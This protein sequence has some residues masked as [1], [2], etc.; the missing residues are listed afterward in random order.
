MPFNECTP[1]SVLAEFMASKAASGIEI[2][3]HLILDGTSNEILSF[4]RRSQKEAGLVLDGAP[5]TLQKVAH[6]RIGSYWKQVVDELKDRKEYFATEDGLVL[7]RS[8]PESMMHQFM[9]PSHILGEDVVGPLD[10]I[11][12]DMAM[13]GVVD[14]AEYKSIVKRYFDGID[15]SDFTDGQ[16]IY[17]N[18]Y[19]D[20]LSDTSRF[21]N[22]T[23]GDWLG[24]K[25]DAMVKGTVQLSPTVIGGN[26]IE[27]FMKGIP[28][29]GKNFLRGMQDLAKLNNGNLMENLFAE[30]P[31]I[32]QQGLYGIEAPNEV[33]KGLL[34]NVTGLMDRPAK[35]LMYFVGLA[36]GGNAAAG[37]KAIQQVMFLPRMADVPLSYRQPVARSATRLLNYTIGTYNLFGSTILAAK[38]NPTPENVNRLLGLLGTYGTVAGIPALMA[39]NGE[40][41][42]DIPFIGPIWKAVASVSS[43][44]L[45][46]RLSIPASQ[47]SSQLLQPISKVITKVS[48]GKFDE[49]DAE[50]AWKFASA[51]AFGV[52]PTGGA[53]EELLSNQLMQRAVKNGIKGVSGEKTGEEAFMD[54]VLPSYNR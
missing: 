33:A 24:Q 9:N 32:K 46:N 6:Q 52:A 4:V 18:E 31:E 5:Q 35:N 40:N 34:E 48:T 7:T 36:D 11:L 38:N 49:I 2:P 47:L 39:A 44:N 3:E 51:L 28:L 23:K 12:V 1:K 16:Q 43:V 15:T 27:P 17:F 26:M 41:V 25:M 19:R 21:A 13:N 14:G 30:I 8:T 50:D 10:D 45:L 20:A 42:E 54:T 53:A 22:I 37:R 29:Y